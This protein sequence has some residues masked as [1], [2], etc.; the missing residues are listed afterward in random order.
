M[1]VATLDDSESISNL[2]H[3][4]TEKYIAHEFSIDGAKNLLNS[5]K[6]DVKKSWGLLA[7]WGQKRK[8]V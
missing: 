1:R 5:M 2:V 7:N 6:A 4:L 8:K 3:G